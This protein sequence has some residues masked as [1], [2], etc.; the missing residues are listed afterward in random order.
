MR[1]CDSAA[2]LRTRL[3]VFASRD[4]RKV[5]NKRERLRHESSG[6]WHYIRDLN[7]GSDAE[8]A[9]FKG[10]CLPIDQVRG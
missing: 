1:G 2:N 5:A 7:Y 3:P 4:N 9:K 10:T 6:V 8:P